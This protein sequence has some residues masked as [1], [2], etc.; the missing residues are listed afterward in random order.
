MIAG[1]KGCY[2]LLSAVAKNAKMK[3]LVWVP[4]CEFAVAI[5]PHLWQT[6][7]LLDAMKQARTQIEN[8][9]E[10]S[11]KPGEPRKWYV[12]ACLT[13]LGLALTSNIETSAER[14]FATEDDLIP[15]DFPVFYLGG[16][17]ALQ[18]GATPLYYPP[19]DRSQGYTLLYKYADDATPWAQM[20]RA[21][22][23]PQSPPIY[24]S[25]FFRSAHGAFGDDAVAVG[26]SH[27]ANHHHHF[28]C[29]QLYS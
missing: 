5:R 9:I 11:V 25:S 19:A 4:G 23:L 2:Q 18:R 24:Q 20:A 28:N 22:G 13:I 12:F 1:G 6:R 21:D 8:R 7:K 27:L 16:K 3:I 29:G 10:Q 26:L 17:V 15:I 14:A